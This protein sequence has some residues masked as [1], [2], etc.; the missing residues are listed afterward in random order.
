MAFYTPKI[1][2]P[3]V[4]GAILVICILSSILSVRRVVVLEPAVVFRG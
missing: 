2:L 3:I 1:L 4:A